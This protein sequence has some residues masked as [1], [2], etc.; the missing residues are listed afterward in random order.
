MEKEAKWKLRDNSR[1]RYRIPKRQ[2]EFK[3]PEDAKSIA[4]IHIQIYKIDSA[5]ESHQIQKVIQQRENPEREQRK[6]Q[7][8]EQR[9]ESQESYPKE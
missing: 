6:S 2:P 9:R 3:L 5:K 7:E 1:G 4:H 8:K